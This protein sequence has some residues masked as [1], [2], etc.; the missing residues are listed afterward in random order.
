MV[1]PFQIRKLDTIR[2]SKYLNIAQN[3]VFQ[4][5]IEGD[6]I[7]TEGD[8]R[9]AEGVRRRTEGDPIKSE[10]DRN[11]TEGDRNSTEGDFLHLN[12]YLMHQEINYSELS[13][14]PDGPVETMNLRGF[15][16]QQK[17]HKQFWSG[18]ARMPALFIRYDVPSKS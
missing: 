4:I 6:Q 7:Q 15:V 3:I 14:E 1:T 2:S 9:P 18:D 10:G 17:F 16:L 11:S 5:W 12:I 8:R 13:Y